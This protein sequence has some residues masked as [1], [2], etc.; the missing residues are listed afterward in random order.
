MVWLIGVV[1]VVVVAGALFIRSRPDRF[2]VERNALIHAPADVVF[3]MINDFQQWRQWS[4]YEKLDPNVTR[5]FEGPASG[6]GSIYGWSGNSKAGAGQ[7]TIVE[8]RPGEL[9]AIQF[10]F[11]KP[12]AA[13]NHGTFKLE[14]AGIGTRVT[15][16]VE[17]ENTVMGKV[18]SAFFDMDALLGK[19]FEEGLANLDR[20]VRSGTQPGQ[21]AGGQATPA[22]VL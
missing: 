18:I 3:G 22:L 20:A 21:G 4:P 1:G 16:S 9:V 12:F 6:T 10:E 15:W 7:M 14:P 17:G 5:R 11:Y 19:N 2:R 8:S 13:T